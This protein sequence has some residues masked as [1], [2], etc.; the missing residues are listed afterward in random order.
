MLRACRIAPSIVVRTHP[1]PQ[2]PGLLSGADAVI[3]TL[4]FFDFST[5]H[6]SLKW[7]KGAVAYCCTINRLLLFAA[8]PSHAAT[9]EVLG[10]DPANRLHGTKI[11][12][13]KERCDATQFQ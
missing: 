11:K 10:L 7:V 4:F 12:T 3:V 6:L 13:A 5:P 1:L 8:G 9:F 2:R